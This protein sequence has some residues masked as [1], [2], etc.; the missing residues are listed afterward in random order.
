M[1]LIRPLKMTGGLV[2]GAVLILMGSLGALGMATSGEGIRLT[3]VYDNYALSE[4]YTTDWGFACMI[5]GTEKNILLDTGN[6]ADIFFDNMDIL[7]VRPQDANL[8]VISHTHK[9][10]T[11]GLFP[12]LDINSDVSVYLPTSFSQQY[13]ANIEATG[14]TVVTPSTA[15]EICKDV[16]LTGPMGTSMIEQSLVMDTAMGIVVITGCGH[17]GIVKIV[18]KAKEMLGKDVYLVL[19]GFHLMS[20]RDSQVLDIIQEF[21]GLGVQKVGP[22]HCTG[23]RAIE[24][25][26]REYGE[27][28]VEFG[29]GEISIPRVYDV[30][31]DRLVNFRDFA[32]WA[33]SWKSQIGE[34]LWDPRMDMYPPLFGDGRVLFDDLFALAGHW[35]E[36]TS[37]PAP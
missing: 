12:F 24:L 1:K 37:L 7:G 20:K 19:G 23:D 3:V 28:F 2:I 27:D 13:I 18:Q 6:D 11:T 31:G 21:R 29:V 22:S 26:S 30:T 35:L 32:D 34:P 10:H 16:H 8:V 36:D 25:F 14:A 9:D 5:T 17:P 4:D 33:L 15:V